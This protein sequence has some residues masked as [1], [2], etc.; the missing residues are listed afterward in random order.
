MEMSHLWPS[1]K[2]YAFEPVP[3][4]FEELKT[5]TRKRANVLCE[6]KALGDRDGFSTFFV[7]SGDSDASSSLLP[8]KEHLRQHP[9]VLFSE[10]IQVTTTT[11]DT[12]AK[13]NGI[14]QIHLLWLDM[15]GFELAALKATNGINQT[16]N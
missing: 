7:S 8:P 5:N 10:S 16:L 11:L 2:I 12:W 14:K 3:W 13:H 1:A 9:K 6:M 4:I 15:Q